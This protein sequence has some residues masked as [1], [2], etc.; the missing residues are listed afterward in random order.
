MKN[1]E[2]LLKQ[3]QKE[4]HK[5]R[6]CDQQSFHNKVKQE[7]AR[8][9]IWCRAFRNAEFTEKNFKDY[10]K[11]EQIKLDFWTKKTIAEMFFDYEYTFNN[12][13]NKWTYKKK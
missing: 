3:I 8:F 5:Q 4:N 10:Q 9:C 1:C 11:E 2:T 13:T 7:Y 6:I 12:E